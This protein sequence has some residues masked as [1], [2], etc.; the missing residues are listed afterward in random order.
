MTTTNTIFQAASDLYNASE[1]MD[2][3]TAVL[4]VL[5]KDATIY[6]IIRHVSKSGMTRV[7]DAMVI[8]DDTPIY[9][10]TVAKDIG[11]KLDRKH[12]GITVRGTGMDMAWHLVSM[13]GSAIHNDEW[14]FTNRTI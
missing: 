11:L 8:I 13:F 14:H 9:L 3:A 7:I 4:M 6:T 12:G 1:D 10:R 5:P 2:M